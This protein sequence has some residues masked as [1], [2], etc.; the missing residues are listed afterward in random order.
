MRKRLWEI[1]NARREN[2]RTAKIFNIF[3]FTLI[4][5][6][7]IAFILDSEKNIQSR[8]GRQFLWFETISILLFTVEYLCR[9]FSCSNEAKYRGFSG[10]LKFIFSPLALIDLLAI[11]PFYLPFVGLDLRVV[12]IFRLF[13]AL[14]I[15]RA[16]RYY[17]ALKLIGRVFQESKEELVITSGFMLV[18]LLLSAT[19]IYFAENESQP[20]AFSSIPA[21]M[22]WSLT[23]F[24]NASSCI[25][26][27][28]ITGKIIGGM[29][30]IFG[31][32][33][34]ALPVSIFGAG[35]VEQIRKN[36]IQATED[37]LICPH[38]GKKIERKPDHIGHAKEAKPEN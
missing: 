14:R 20:N 8:F 3:L 37:T 2:D 19:L 33:M 7:I 23:T 10:K 9:L 12:R 22:W 29:V 27:I 34:F 35:F 38:C 28:T 17:K 24:T 31:I 15:F 21:S 6:N 18:L 30:A 13:M 5:L 4:V 32:G 36:K 1:L 11:I 16:S 25:T 26:P